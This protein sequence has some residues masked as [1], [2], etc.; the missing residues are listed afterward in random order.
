MTNEQISKIKDK[1]VEIAKEKGCY[2]INVSESNGQFE[3]TFEGETTFSLL[4]A[5]SKELGTEN[6]NCGNRHIGAIGCRTCNGSYDEHVIT[7]WDITKL[8]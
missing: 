3:L 4:D 6:I 2:T 1:I 7:I 8:V 5:L